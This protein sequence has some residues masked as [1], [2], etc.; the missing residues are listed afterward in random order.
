MY[1]NNFQTYAFG[2]IITFLILFIA[3]EKDQLN[4]T[5][6]DFGSKIKIELNGKATIGQNGNY[7]IVKLEQVDDSR[8]PSDVN[9]ITAGDAMV[10]INVVDIR[11]NQASFDLF[12]GQKSSFKPDTLAFSIDQKN[13][14]M[15][16]S[17][18][19][20]YP[21]TNQKQGNKNVELA[22]VAN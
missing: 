16:L 14:K 9:C 3:C 5:T 13:Y 7:L 6:A 17:N 4:N 21:A 2:T 22:I 10:R 19:L 11:D 18:V 15:I 8:C 12:Y 20:P 1:L